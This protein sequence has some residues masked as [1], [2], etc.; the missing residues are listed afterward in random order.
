MAVLELFVMIVI[1]CWKKNGMDIWVLQDYENR[2]W[3]REI[4]IFPESLIKLGRPFP[5]DSVN[6]DESI[7][8]SSNFSG[9]VMNVLTYNR[10]SRCFKSVQ[11]TP[12]HQFPLTR[13]FRFQHVSCYVE[14]MVPL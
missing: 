13:T 1:M 6:M 12:G 9:D 10:K 5:I 4:I 2:V 11:F 3:V 7:F 14:R 8:S